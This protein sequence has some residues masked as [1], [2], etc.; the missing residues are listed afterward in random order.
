MWIRPKM[1]K[2]ILNRQRFPGAVSDC[3]GHTW[4]QQKQTFSSSRWW[5]S[6]DRIRKLPGARNKQRRQRTALQSRS[7]QQKFRGKDHCLSK[8][9][10]VCVGFVL[11]WSYNS[12]KYIHTKNNITFISLKTRKEPYLSKIFAIMKVAF[13]SCYGFH[14][15]F[16]VFKKVYSGAFAPWSWWGKRENSALGIGSLLPLFPSLRVI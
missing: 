12:L 5:W 13:V 10:C 4:R 9:F 6:N 1:Q 16:A 8:L 15:R 14:W 2:W 3:I 7:L 11:T